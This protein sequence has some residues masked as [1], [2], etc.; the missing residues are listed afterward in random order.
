[1]IAV[2]HLQTV[3]RDNAILLAPTL[4]ANWPSITGLDRIV[5]EL[6]ESIRAY[7]PDLVISDFEV[8]S[9]RAA[10]RLGIPTIS[11]NHQQIVTETIYTVPAEY[12]IDAQMAKAIINLIAPKNPAR[13]L[14]TS[15]FYPRLKRTKNTFLIPPIIRKE[16]ASLRPVTGKH[17]LVYYNNQFA[18]VKDF[19]ELLRK[20]GRPY[21]VYNLPLPPNPSH[22]PNIIFKKTSLNEFLVDLA[23]CCAVLC[24]AGFTLISEALYLNK[25]V[26]AL[27]NRG[28]FEQTINALFLEREG[29]GKA[30]IHRPLNIS[31]LEDFYS[32]L[33]H[34]IEATR[35]RQNI[36]NAEALRI[37]ED[38]LPRK[39]VPVRA[40]A[41]P[42][43]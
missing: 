31:D 35:V 20:D 22:Y 30:V 14:L 11:F 39:R 25:P 13:L 12:W 18:D 37:I 38:T 16:V 36:G 26:L 34:Y 27:P 3:I 19:R 32:N 23:S 40:T 42:F 1:M 24:T 17:T 29:L 6:A 5:A 8:F 9:W 33:S 43:S 2:P 21:I 4:F 7:G 41:L 10:E 15:F 28:I